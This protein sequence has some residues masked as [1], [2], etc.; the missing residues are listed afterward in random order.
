MKKYTAIEQ[1]KKIVGW[2]EY[3]DLPDWNI[4][5]LKA[6]IDTGAKSS[7]IHVEEIEEISKTKISFYVILDKD[8]GRKKIIAKPIHKGKV[9]SSIGVKTHRWYV[10]TKVRIGDIERKIRI[11]LVGRE[12]MNFRMLIGRTALENDF[13]VD[14]SHS[15]V[16]KS[17]NPKRKQNVL[18]VK[19]KRRVLK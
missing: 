10:E 7:S 19:K 8:R 6:K 9:K 4:K 18:K 15:Y 16:L 12:E 17:K 3:I 11:N 1:K 5:K 14:A 13:L 2:R